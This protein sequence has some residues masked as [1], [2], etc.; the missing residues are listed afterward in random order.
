ME[1]FPLQT[2]TQSHDIL[3]LRVYG[4]AK[5]LPYWS[6]I[7]HPSVPTNRPG[8]KGVIRNR[9][10]SITARITTQHCCNADFQG[11]HCMKGLLHERIIACIYENYA[12]QEI[13]GGERVAYWR[14]CILNYEDTVYWINTVGIALTSANAS[15]LISMHHWHYTQNMASSYKYVPVHIAFILQYIGFSK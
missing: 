11:S 8:G 3:I 1:Y 15:V 4:A 7:N 9:T 6:T 5:D 10:C 2:C 13:Y 12:L 14:H